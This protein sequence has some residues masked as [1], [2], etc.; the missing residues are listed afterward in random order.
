MAA[1]SSALVALRAAG[2]PQSTKDPRR[3]E[4]NRV[5]L[6]SRDHGAAPC[7]RECRS[8]RRGEDP[9]PPGRRPVV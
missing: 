3:R 7:R 2:W 6:A 5:G 9:T 8:A 1:A 4:G